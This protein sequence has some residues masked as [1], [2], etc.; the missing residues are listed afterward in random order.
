[1]GCPTPLGMSYSHE[2][3]L[4]LK[5]KCMQRSSLGIWRRQCWGTI[6]CGEG[7]VL[8][9]LWSYQMVTYI[10]TGLKAGPGI[11]AESR[12]PCPVFDS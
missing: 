9:N 5:P 11:F 10:P 3:A 2:T 6:Y 7:V 1:M 12:K 8:I 4:C